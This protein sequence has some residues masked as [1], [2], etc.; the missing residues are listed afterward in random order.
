MQEAYYC[1]ARWGA[2]AKTDRLEQTYPKLL[3]PILQRV[4][5]QKIPSNTLT[6][7]E[8]LATVTST[9]SA[10]DVTSAIKAGRAISGEIELDALLSKL[11][12]IVRENAGAALILKD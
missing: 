5:P 12:R 10:L 8:T 1:Y 11:I 2:K 4:E 3:T 7:T 9:A 6:G